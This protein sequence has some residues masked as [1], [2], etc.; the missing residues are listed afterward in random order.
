MSDQQ[1]RELLNLLEA[2]GKADL[3]QIK[4]PYAK[5]ALTPVMSQGQIDLHYGKL[6]KGYVE[7]FNSG[8]GDAT[9]NEA[10]AFLHSLWFSQF[11]SPKTGN[12]PVGQCETLINKKYGNFTAFKAELKEQA[13]KLQGSAWIYMARNGEIKSFKNHQKR[14]DIA[15]LIDWWEHSWIHDYGSNKSKYFDDLWRI[16]DWSVI[17]HRLSGSTA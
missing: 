10:G 2:K 5:T 1:I 4:L 3:K 17:N 9:F 6:Y 14:S 12:K 8:E 11:R 15:L 13:M 7:R 16:V